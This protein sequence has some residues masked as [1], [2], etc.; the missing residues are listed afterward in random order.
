VHDVAVLHFVGLAF[1]AQLSGGLEA[2][3]AVVLFQ[4]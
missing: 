2:G 3:F 4:I 1:D